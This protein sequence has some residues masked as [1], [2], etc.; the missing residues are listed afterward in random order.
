[1][2]GW[3]PL[4]DGAGETAN[5]IS[6]NDLAATINNVDFGGLGD[7][8]SA[9]AEDPEFGTVLSFNGIDNSGAYAVVGN[10]PDS[11]T[12]PIFTTEADS[13]FTW[14]FWAKSE[15]AANNDIILGNRRSSGGGDF[16]PRQFIKF[17]TRMFEWDTNN[18]QGLDY[19]DIPQGVWIH[20]VVVKSGTELLYYRDG[21]ESGTRTIVAAPQDPQPIYFGGQVN[22]CWAGYMSDVRLYNSALSESEVQ[23]VYENRGLF[24]TEDDDE[25]GLP[26]SWEEALVD[27]LDDLNGN[28]AGPGPGSGTGDF[29]GDGLTD[30][31]EYEETKTDPTKADTDGDGLSD[32]VETNTGTYV[33]ATNTGTNPK[34]VDTD[35]DGLADGVETNTGVLVDEE[36]TG[37]NPL[38]KDSD[39]DGYF[40]G[41]EIVGGT[42]PNDENSK[43]AI[44]APTLYVDFESEAS[45]L[46][47]NDYVGEVNN[48]VT[49]DVEGAEGGPTPTTGAS[50]NG[51]YINYPGV[52]L[53]SIIQDIEGE[54]SYTFSAWIKPSDLNGDKFLFGQTS[55]GIHNG[56]RGGGFLHQAHWGADNNGATNLSTLEGEWVHAAW[57][58]DGSTDTGKMYLNGVL[59]AD[60]NKRAPNG[61]GNLIVG[62]RNGGTENY[63]GLVDDVAFWN[64]VLPEGSIQALADGASPIGASQ[65]D[66]DGDGLPDAWEEKYGVDD[67]EGD[68]DN[69]GLTNVEEFEL[70]TKPNKADSDEDGLSDKD[71]I[72]VHET[73]PLNPDADRDGLLDGAEIA[74]GTDPDKKDTDDDGIS[75]FNEIE[76]GTDPLVKTAIAFDTNLVA[77]WPMDGSFDNAQTD[78]YHGIED[79]GPIEFQTGKF[80]DAVYLNGSQSIEIGGDENVFDFAGESFT[81]SAWYTAEEINKSWQCLVAKGEGNGWRVHR[82]GGDNPPE[83]TFTGGNGDVDR[84]NVA[85]EVGGD[86][87]TWHHVAGVTDSETSEQILYL[88]GEEVARKAG[89]T[90][91]DRGNPMRIGDNPDAR[92]RNW[93]GKVDD[94]AIWGRALAPFEIADIWN[95]GDGK[96]IEEMLGLA[97]PFEFTSIIYNAEE[98]GFKLEWNSK[99]NK[100]Y[101][102]Y[103][104][105]TLEEF[106]ADIDDSIESQ[107]ETTVYPGGDEWLQNPLE[108]APRL[109]F[110]IE[111]NQ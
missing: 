22:E 100:T 73:N 14:S 81:V 36:N 5:D 56:I 72:E 6:G 48:D 40:D 74:A 89:A 50:F 65:E 19:D 103:F 51:G 2:F 1:M 32:A 96:S 86:P 84:H 20:H 104:S 17:T 39:G 99:P 24:S 15:Q 25:D 54:N 21:I 61:N 46:S 92:N 97:I 52:D 57:T 23:V 55:Q 80:G 83:M 8:D 82:R 79:G 53:S 75:D 110:R 44:P 78:D 3:W 67:P 7:G 47:G 13:E 70:R 33:S 41:G 45:D 9:W 69:D 93:L 64:E 59:D 106:D 76:N 16:S 28:G 105:E 35:S 108:G 88:D 43:G 27:N 98:D 18:V 101:A 34:K 49:F 30:L 71:E 87:E 37:T 10:P 107:G 90:L 94:V 68:D 85:M 66:D 60:V 109:F 4:N 62:G 91:Q 77:Y 29:D 38:N 42:D 31:D 58:Y 12:L 111:E 95:N 26:D 63:L 11:G 102:L